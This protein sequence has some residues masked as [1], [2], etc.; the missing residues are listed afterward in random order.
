M[1]ECEH[2]LSAYPIIWGKLLCK[3]YGDGGVLLSLYMITLTYFKNIIL[4]YIVINI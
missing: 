2:T 3:V 1:Y 4:K